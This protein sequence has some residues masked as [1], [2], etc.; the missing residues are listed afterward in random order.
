MLK[1]TLL[2]FDQLLDKHTGLLFCLLTLV[3]LRVPNFFDPYWYGDEAIYLTLGQSIRSGKTLYSEIVDHKTPIIYYLA[4]VPNQFYFRILLTFWMVIST[5]FFYDIAKRIFKSKF[6]AVIGTF[7]FTLLT[8]LPWFEG[9]IPNG[10]LFVIGFILTGLWI[11]SKSGYLDAVFN[12]DSVQ[13]NTKK[14]PILSLIVGGVF[15]G[16]GFLTKVPALLDFAGAML[17][18]WFF[19]TG[20]LSFSTRKIRVAK[21]FKNCL[22]ELRKKILSKENLLTI[23]KLLSHWLPLIIGFLIPV[24]ISIIYFIAI[25]A[26]QDYLE[27]GL[28][29]NLHYSQSWTHDLG[30]RLL[31]ALFTLPGKTAILALLMLALTSFKNISLKLKFFVGW[32]LLTLYAVLLSNRPYPHYFLQSIPP[33][34][35]MITYLIQQ[36]SCLLSTDKKIHQARQVIISL[37]FNLFSLMLTISIL[38]L[39]NFGVYSNKSYYQ[40]FYKYISGEFNQLEFYQTYNQLMGENYELAAYLKEQE[41]KNLFIWGNNAMLYALSQTV[42]SSRYTVAFHIQDMDAYDET[43]EQIKSNEPKFI[44][45]MN[46]ASKDFPEFYQY[47]AANYLPNYI[48]SQM[49]LYKK[50]SAN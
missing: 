32:Y 30:S 14:V 27:F 31:N 9:H 45:L 35:L 43:M 46:N 44:V 42:P 48:T 19:I 8:S 41:Q 16:L 2:K 38:L 13:F 50:T 3:I 26:G 47:L 18:A 39:L 22:L 40:N 17:L 12:N 20:Q 11:I 24:F 6:F 7:I 34:A 23:T 29:Y 21:D 49:T 28:L 36:V 15:F 1:K 25:D 37:L 33:L 10:E 5:I 4:A